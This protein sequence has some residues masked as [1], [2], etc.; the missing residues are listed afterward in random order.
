MK[1]PLPSLALRC[2]TLPASGHSLAIPALRTTYPSFGESPAA[3]L[4]ILFCLVLRWL[5]LRET[6]TGPIAERGEAFASRTSM[7]LHLALQKRDRTGL[8]EELM[9]L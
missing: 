7:E 3:P 8:R 2:A 1:A 9:P 5:R 6:W 4:T